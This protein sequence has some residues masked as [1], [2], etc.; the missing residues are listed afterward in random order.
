MQ[1]VDRTFASGEYVITEWKLQVT[2]TAPFYGGRTRRVP[3]SFAGASIIWIR[4][5][6]VADWADYYDG[7][8]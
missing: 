1:K 3:I 4:D 8:S 7:S 5:G 2:I 6:K